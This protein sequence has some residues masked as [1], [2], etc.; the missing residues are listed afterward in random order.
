M[1]TEVEV[2]FTIP[3]GSTGNELKELLIKFQ[4]VHGLVN[5]MRD[6]AQLEKE[7]IEVAL[8]ATEAQS[9]I[10]V[11]EKYKMVIPKPGVELK[12][13][14][15]RLLLI[16]QG[17]WSLKDEFKSVIDLEKELAVAVYKVRR[18]TSRLRE[19]ETT[20]DVARSALAWDRR[21]WERTE[22]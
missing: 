8:E 14:E 4:G 6:E 15:A 13:S 20:I 3:E 21:E 18:A 9:F 2:D 22:T 7:T 12:K 5:Q 16:H 17:G 11:S 10:D 19:L 1:T